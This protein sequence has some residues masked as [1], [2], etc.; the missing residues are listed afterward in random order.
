MACNSTSLVQ[1]HGSGTQ[2]TSW[3]PSSRTLRQVSSQQRRAASDQRHPTRRQRRRRRLRTRVGRPAVAS[4]SAVPARQQSSMLKA[5]PLLPLRRP[6]SGALTSRR[7]VTSVRRARGPSSLFLPAGRRA[8]TVRHLRVVGRRALQQ[9]PLLSLRHCLCLRQPGHALPLMGARRCEPAVQRASVLPQQVATSRRA[10][11]NE[12][13][14]A[15]TVRIRPLCKLAEPLSRRRHLKLLPRWCPL[16]VS[17][18]RT[19][20]LS[21]R[22]VSPHHLLP[23]TSSRRARAR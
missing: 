20:C 7:L 4:C 8:R 14:G 10:A 15:K 13:N 19:W 2:T 6:R 16:L 11:C 3:R 9:V 21:R 1:E 18:P 5:R 22:E 12:Y 23:R 17:A